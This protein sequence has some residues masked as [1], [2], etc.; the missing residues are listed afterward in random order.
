M[1]W[2]NGPAPMMNCE[3]QG[4]WGWVSRAYKAPVHRGIAQRLVSIASIEYPITRWNVALEQKKSLTLHVC[5]PELHQE[6]VRPWGWSLDMDPNIESHLRQL[7]HTI[8]RHFC[9]SRCYES[10]NFRCKSLGYCISLSSSMDGVDLL[11]G[12]YLDRLK[13]RRYPVRRTKVSQAPWVWGPGGL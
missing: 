6:M 1:S 11:E 2:G 13:I 3:P 5:S 8:P 7:Y 4:W 10:H 9:G 12:T